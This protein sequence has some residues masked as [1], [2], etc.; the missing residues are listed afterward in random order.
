MPPPGVVT[1]DT[2]RRQARRHQRVPEDRQLRAASAPEAA[3]EHA[4]AREGRA[5]I[6]GRLVTFAYSTRR[7]APQTAMSS[8]IVCAI[9]PAGTVAATP[10]AA[11]E[12]RSS[13]PAAVSRSAGASTLPVAAAGRKQPA[14]LRLDRK[15][16]AD[17]RP[18]T[19]AT[20]VRKSPSL[21][22]VTSGVPSARKRR[23]APPLRRP[24]MIACP[25]T[26]TFPPATIA[27]PYTDRRVA[28]DRGRH[29]PSARPKAR[30]RAVRRSGR[31]STARQAKRGLRERRAGRAG[32]VGVEL[33]HDP[34]PGASAIE[35]LTRRKA[36]RAGAEQLPAG[37][38]AAEKRDA[39]GAEAA[40]RRLCVTFVSRRRSGW[41][42]L[43]R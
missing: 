37:P 33:P 25:A 40:A 34:P 12:P 41:R 8:A 42:Q 11:P 23:R 32:R 7:A 10:R 22:K 38:I 2:P 18:A 3:I 13:C 36:A 1:S 24:I 6:I 27:A 29:R 26:T 14:A 9:P 21:P 5:T 39:V 28:G 30:V 35:P 16:R 17:E 15:R 20:S 43:C 4:G 31:P 19:P